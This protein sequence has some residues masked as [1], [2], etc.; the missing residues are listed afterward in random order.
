MASISTRFDQP[1]FYSI[2]SYLI[3][4]VKRSRNY[5]KLLNKYITEIYSKNLDEEKLLVEMDVRRTILADVNITFFGDVEKSLTSNVVIVY[6][7]LIV[8]PATSCCISGRSFS[9]TRHWKFG[10]QSTWTNQHF[11]SLGLLN[12]HKEL[13]DKLDLAEVGNESVFLNEER[14]Q[15][16]G[17]FVESDSR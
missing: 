17:K 13:T 5:K 16:F 9:T 12:V 15:Y 7:L 10:L 6:N 14:F 4:P 11:N 1:S 2:F 8:N 3:Q